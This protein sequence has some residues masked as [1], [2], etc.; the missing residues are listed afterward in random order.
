[1]AFWRRKQIIIERGL[2]FRFARFVILYMTLSCF[3]TAFIVFYATFTVFSEKLVGIYPQQRL[4][5]I[6]SRA[7]GAFF[8]GLVIVMP[9]LFYGA[10]LFSHRIAGPL[11]K[12]YQALQDIGQGN[13]DTKLSLRKNDELSGLADHI[14]RMAL[15]LKERESKK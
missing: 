3:V 4:P 11:P 12:L 6:F 10:I 13:F 1:M 9:I 2:Q 8:V 5:E 14:N 15:K 7:Y